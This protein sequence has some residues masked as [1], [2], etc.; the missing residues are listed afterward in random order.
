MKILFP[1]I[2]TLVPVAGYGC[3]DWQTE[4]E[5]RLRETRRIQA[6]RENEILRRLHETDRAQGETRRR[7]EPYNILMTD[8]QGHSRLY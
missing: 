1:L 3:D 7:T 6:W 4:F 8:P 5:E 2:L